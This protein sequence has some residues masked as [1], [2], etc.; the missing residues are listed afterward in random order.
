[1]AS[2]RIVIVLLL[3][4]FCIHFMP[5][6]ALAANTA[7]AKDPIIPDRACSLTV[8]YC[9]A[10]TAFAS[11]QVELYQIAT[12]SADFQY[13]LTAPFAASGL[14]LNGIQSTGEWNVIRSTL[15][16]Y[17]IA[18][19]VPADVACMTNEDGMARFEGLPTGLYLAMADKA[20]QGT[21]SYDFDSSLVALPGLSQDGCWEYQLT[22]NAKGEPTPPIDPDAEVQ[23][24]ILKLWKGDNGSA[25]RPE[26]VEVEIFRD[27]NSHE[28]VILS[29]QNHWSYSWWANDDGSD[30]TVSE[31][32]VP[33][34]YTVT[35]EK[36]DHSFVLTN[37]TESED[38]DTP[39]PPTG[40][41]TIM[42]ILI[43]A[44]AGCLLIVV[45]AAGK[46]RKV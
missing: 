3:F 14:I 32:N 21:L 19:K 12:V 10:D 15:E 23:Y 46:R 20:Q 24:K 4:C 31:R 28:T 42:S 33:K 40:D 30:W 16:A 27:G 2:K 45:G 22:V 8:S 34:G 38:P 5:C 11:L 25:D 36:K 9:Y 37:T 39:P 35:V 17:I 1:M 26:S 29:E 7:D 13:T 44:I 41:K 18:N 6:S 43:M